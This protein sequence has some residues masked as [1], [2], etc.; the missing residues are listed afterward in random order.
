MARETRTALFMA[1][2]ISVSFCLNYPCV[3][4]K[5]SYKMSAMNRRDFLATSLGAGVSGSAAAVLSE[6]SAV[7]QK[8]SAVSPTGRL[9]QS[10][11]LVNFKP[12]TPLDEICRIAAGAGCQALDLI[13]PKDWPILRKYGLAPSTCPR[14][15]MTI[16][17]GMIRK[18]VQDNVEKSMHSLIDLSAANGCRNM[19]AVGGQRRGIS[20]EE[21]ADI[22][23]AFLNRLKAHA[24]D[25]GINICLEIMNSKLA[26]PA[27]GRLDQVC[28]HVAW[29]VQ[30]C[31]RVNSPRVK[32]LFDI[33]H[34][35][36]MDGDICRNI[37]EN[38]QWIGHFHTGGVP[39]RHEI[40]DTQEI[41]Y[42]FVAK[43]IADLGF[44]GYIAH[45]YTL[46]LG[47]DAAQSLKQAV[48]T[49]TV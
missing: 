20:Y 44:T 3:F 36:I 2:S 46:G 6:V 30:V 21:G 42:H 34:V 29:G 31:R 9:K 37:Q 5:I 22:C 49:M 41:N 48:T 17:D 43:T 15:V 14:D 27:L 18:E 11:M 23:V 8:P 28:D 13:P 12:G 25:K 1:T 26:P 7:A 39:G 32:L 10:A 38:I 33:Y 19:I 47:R 16:E 35:Q 24:E 40:D 4:A 45:E